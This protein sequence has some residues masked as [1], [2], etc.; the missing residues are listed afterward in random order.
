MSTVIYT[1][2]FDDAQWPSDHPLNPSQRELLPQLTSHIEVQPITLHVT[3]SQAMIC[4]A[5][6]AKL[7]YTDPA[8]MLRSDAQAWLHELGQPL[9]TDLPDWVV[10]AVGLMQY[11]IPPTWALLIAS[12]DGG[13]TAWFF[14]R[15]FMLRSD[16][17][18]LL[19][20]RPEGVKA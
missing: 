19:S 16:H 1:T 3:D 6:G 4:V 7:I 8:S 20:Q 18:Y 10:E 9:R 14:F 11:Y 17:P 5:D 13:E 2:S 15:R 12:N